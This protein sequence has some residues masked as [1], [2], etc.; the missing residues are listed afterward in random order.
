[1]FKENSI[2]IFI[3]G[4]ESDSWKIYQIGLKKALQRFGV[5]KVVLSTIA[6][7]NSMDTYVILYFDKDIKALGGIRVEVKT[8]NN[9]MPI[10]KAEIN[11][12]HILLNKIKKYSD[13]NE[14]VAEICGLWVCEEAKGLGLGTQ[15]A[16]EATQLGVKL[17]ID[18]L[19]SM[20]PVHTLNYF[21]KLGF[22]ED[23]EIPKLAYPDDRYLSTIVWLYILNSKKSKEIEEQK[24]IE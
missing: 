9:R 14:I 5:E 19:V 18:I 13:Q 2:K 23:N 17:K 15:L 12:R 24:K 4:E 7:E 8:L 6:E 11:Y 21:L 3:S 1:M 16:F 10:E 20:L 22:I